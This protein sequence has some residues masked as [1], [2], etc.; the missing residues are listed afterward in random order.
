MP[1]GSRSLDRVAAPIFGAVRQHR[2]VRSDGGRDQRPQPLDPVQRL[3]P[4]FIPGG[5]RERDG[6][7]HR[8]SRAFASDAACAEALESRLIGRRGRDVGARLE[9]I[10]MHLANEVRALEQA[11]RRPQRIVEI[12]SAALE[13]RRERAVQDEHALRRQRL[14]DRAGSRRH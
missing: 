2:T 10:E 4:E 3:G 11:F 12:G 6:V 8:S 14:G 9:I 7:A 1:R 5:Q 13:F